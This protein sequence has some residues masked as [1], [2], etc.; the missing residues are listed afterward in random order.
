MGHWDE[1]YF[2]HLE[3]GMAL[4]VKTERRLA[5]IALGQS[6]REETVLEQG[7]RALVSAEERLALV[8][9]EEYNIEEGVIGFLAAERRLSR[10][11]TR[12]S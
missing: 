6:R 5:L 4:Q 1:I 12:G 7:M 9:P 11:L 2:L 10:V 3:E 8:D